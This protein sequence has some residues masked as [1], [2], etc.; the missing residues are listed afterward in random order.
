MIQIKIT[1]NVTLKFSSHITCIIFNLKLFSDAV[2]SISALTFIK[3]LQITK[4]LVVKLVG[5][6]DTTTTIQ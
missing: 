5:N 6:F 4:V 3:T 2:V 1:S